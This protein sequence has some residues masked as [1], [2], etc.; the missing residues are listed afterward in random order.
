MYKE[1]D[2]KRPS[3]HHNFKTRHS[4]YGY[5]VNV[6]DTYRHLP[7]QPFW[8]W[9]TGKS[10]VHHKPRKPKETLLS[11]FQLILQLLWSWG[12]IFLFFTFGYYALNNGE[13]S[14]TT[15]SIIVVLS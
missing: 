8:T 5:G 1:I 13:Q 2:L 3:Q 12:L 6:R 14:N 15:R 4:K 10:L 11:S 9:L 7:F